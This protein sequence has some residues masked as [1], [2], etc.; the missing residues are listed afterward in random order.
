MRLSVR[1]FQPDAVV[2]TFL[3]LLDIKLGEC[4]GC[5]ATTRGGV[6]QVVCSS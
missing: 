3:G 1:R 5:G 4:G 6:V 2:A